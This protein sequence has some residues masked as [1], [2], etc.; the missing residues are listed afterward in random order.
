[1]ILGALLT[2]PE[3]LTQIVMAVALQLLYEVSVWIAWYW[4]RKEKKAEKS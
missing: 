4:E 1:M 2:T 3:V